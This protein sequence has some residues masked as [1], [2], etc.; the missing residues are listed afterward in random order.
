[1]GMI[2]TNKPV[3]LDNF[4][5]VF[6]EAVKKRE[7]VA[8][9]EEALVDILGLRKFAV[10]NDLKDKVVETY[11]EQALISQH[12]Y[13]QSKDEADLAE[14]QKTIGEAEKYVSEHQ[15]TKW[16]SRLARYK[17]R[18]CDYKKEYS[19]AIEYF[20]EA[21]DKSIT[22]P[23]YETNSALAFE[24]RGFLVIDKIRLSNI[25]EGIKEAVELYD[26]Y[27][28]T[29]EGSALRQKDYTTW[30]I[31]RSAVFINLCKALIDMDL[32]QEHRHSIIE[33]LQSASNNL[34]APE[35]VTVWSDF[36]FRKKEIVDLQKILG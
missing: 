26:D 6:K 7:D 29:E 2:D 20:Q 8:R 25:E 15:L 4:D 1:M 33:W 3:S 11:F 19:K 21:I 23:N 16:E 36:A 14:M 35:G 27:L 9:Q 30:A 18:I 10:E 32:A 28:F 31:W 13:M 24:Y 5:L 17:G 34:K 22:D 12:K